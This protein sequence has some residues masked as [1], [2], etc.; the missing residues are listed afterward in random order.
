M[1]LPMKIIII[2]AIAVLVLTVLLT[3]FLRSTGGAISDADANRIFNTQCAAYSQQK[4]S[5][6]VT[7][8]ADFPAYVQACR[9][10]Y[11]EQRDSYSCLYTLCQSCFETSDLK[12]SGLCN[13]CNGHE[14]A[15]VS[16][17]TC[18]STYKTQCQT[19]CDAC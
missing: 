6:D 11:G 5:W 16:R 15:S 8:G 19:K 7:Y 10:I 2:A 1:E 3:F 4:C 14:A 17:A 18:C 12:C 13:I 9:H